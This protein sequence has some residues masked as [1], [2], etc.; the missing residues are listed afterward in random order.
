[1][2]RVESLRSSFD[3]YFP[4]YRGGH[5]RSGRPRFRMAPQLLGHEIDTVG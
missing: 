4:G 2:K 5:L 3:F 1:M